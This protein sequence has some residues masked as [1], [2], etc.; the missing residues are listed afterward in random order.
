MNINVYA[1]QLLLFCVGENQ[2]QP[3][4]TVKS[5]NYKDLTNFLLLSCGK[6]FNFQVKRHFDCQSMASVRRI[7]K[8][9]E[10]N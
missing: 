4:I 3:L 8:N 5:T 1:K 7:P 6:H 10:V 2:S 9:A